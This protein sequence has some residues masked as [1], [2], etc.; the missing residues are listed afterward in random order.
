MKKMIL[1]FM[2]LVSTYAFAHYAVFSM[3]QVKNASGN[4]SVYNKTYAG[5]T[6]IVEFKNLGTKEIA[7]HHMRFNEPQES[8]ILSINELKVGPGETAR[9][10]FF[11]VPVFLRSVDFYVEGETELLEVYGVLP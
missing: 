11:D 2:A 1:S 10:V 9:E 5:K 7:I 8:T 3:G 6:R 4:T